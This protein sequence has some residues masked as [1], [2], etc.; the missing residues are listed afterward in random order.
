MEKRNLAQQT[1]DSLYGRIVN[2]GTWGPGDRLPNENE[3]A[4][5]LGV[6]RGTLREAIRLLTAQGI[7]TAQK[8]R[9]TFVAENASLPGRF[10][11]ENLPVERSRLADL[12]EA[13]LLLEPELAAL[14]CRRASREE[15]ERILALAEQVRQDILAGNKR[16]DSDQRFHQAIAAAAHNDFLSHLS[17]IINQAVAESLRLSEYEKALS[18]CTLQDHA[19]LLTFL[20]D[21]DGAGAKRAMYLH[22]RRAMAI[23][24]LRK[25]D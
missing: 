12:F 13:R 11:L 9:G 10:D 8:G 6:S 7:L 25:P 19:L 20:R 22:L 14:A 1:A 17:P 15:L 16:T 2:G 23:L 5:Q 21:R 3:L 4:E 18:E 24:G